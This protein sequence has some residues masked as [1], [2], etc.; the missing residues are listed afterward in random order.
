MVLH[1]PIHGYLAVL[2]I[3]IPNMVKLNLLQ[4][5]FIPFFLL[6]I[7][8]LVRFNHMVPHDVLRSRIRVH[9]ICKELEQKNAKLLIHRSID[10]PYIRIFVVLLNVIDKCDHMLKVLS[11]PV[12]VIINTEAYRALTNSNSNRRNKAH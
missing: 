10:R 11:S 7:I 8:L 12:C 9:I 4:N 3:I 6:V 5:Q 1:H 2:Q